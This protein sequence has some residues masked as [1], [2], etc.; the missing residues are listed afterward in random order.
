[1]YELEHIRTDLDNL[2]YELYKQDPHSNAATYLNKALKA[3]DRALVSLTEEE[4]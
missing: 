3:I 4:R 1:M 2:Q